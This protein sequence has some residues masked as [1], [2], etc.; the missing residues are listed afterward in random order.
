MPELYSQTVQMVVDEVKAQFGEAGDVQITSENIIRW[1]NRG[2]REIAV[3]TQFLKGEVSINTV[4]GQNEYDLAAEH[5]LRLDSVFISGSPVPIIPVE[6]AD[7]VY[8]FIDPN[9]T[10]T[11]SSTE[12]AWYDDGVI[13]LYPKPSVGVTNGLRVKYLKYPAAVAVVG[14]TLT[15][16]DRFFNQLLQFCLAQ[17][18]YL[19]ADHE[20]HQADMERFEEGL[21]RQQNLQNA[22]QASEYP[23]IGEDPADFVYSTGDGYFD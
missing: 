7:R 18:Q 9:E 12:A 3:R 17:A 19:D 20:Q 6:Q 13:H 2:S 8:R 23:T 10:S 15:V 22:N 11:G 4:A 1:I 5:V 16:P 21:A 14:D